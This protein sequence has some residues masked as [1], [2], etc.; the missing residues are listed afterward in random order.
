MTGI[1]LGL[2]F[3]GGMVFGVAAVVVVAVVA[4][5][6][7]TRRGRAPVMAIVAV[8]LCLAGWIRAPGET[9]VP[10]VSAG[11]ASLVGAVTSQPAATR[12]GQSFVLTSSEGVGEAAIIACVVSRN[13][14]VVHQG[15]RVRVQGRL[16]PLEDLPENRRA[17]LRAR[18]CQ[19]LID[20][21][22]VIVIRRASGVAG[23]LSGIREEIS[24]F[25]QQTAPGN[26]GALM[27]G[28]LI[29]DDSALSY[30]AEEAFI[31]TGTTHITAVSGANF[32]ILVTLASMLAGSS[33]V[34]RRWSWIL[35]LSLGIWFYA[36]LVGLPPSAV[37]A[38]IMAT[39][40]LF[41]ARA[42][43]IPDFLTL[44]VVTAA[45]QVAIRPGDLTTLSFQL[46]VAATLAL[47]LV[48]SG[49]QPS[50]ARTMLGV[51]VCATAAHLATAPILAYHL[52]EI[53]VASIPAN[54][55]IVPLVAFAFYFAAMSGVMSLLLPG[56]AAVLAFPGVLA[57]SAIVGIVSWVSSSTGKGITIGRLPDPLLFL[58][59]IGC[60]GGI[61]MSS[62]D[63]RV[64]FDH[65]LTSIRKWVGRLR[66]S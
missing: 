23:V 27:T 17:A 19:A 36:L 43:R 48:F 5:L 4:V 57:S 38:A 44:L 11:E 16:S 46:S 14:D 54:A 3:L 65:Y 56:L 51:I 47:I 33:G 10:A 63:C 37:R 52:G 40:A 50:F 60:W 66:S 7:A 41:A 15:A 20:A 1:L 58:L 45:A 13:T 31:V 28:L 21:D 64:A 18:G 49:W 22:R 61:A 42:G 39:L 30:E 53:P 2:S 26:P 62:R 12:L 6:Q 8:V 25:F 34:R 59:A 24:G 35:G 9:V 55:M 32:A 29:G